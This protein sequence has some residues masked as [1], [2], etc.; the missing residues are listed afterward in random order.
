MIPFSRLLRFEDSIYGHSYFIRAAKGAIRC[1][2]DLY[3]HPEWREHADTTQLT[4]ESRGALRA[5]TNKNRPQ[6]M[7]P[8]PKVLSVSDQRPT[9]K[10]NRAVKQVDE[11]PS[12]R[13]LIEDKDVLREALPFL[14]KLKTFA[15]NDIDVWVLGYHLYKRLG[16][17]LLQLQALRKGLSVDKGDPDLHLCLI[18]FLLSSKY[19]QIGMTLHSVS[20]VSILPLGPSFSYK[21]PSIM[22]IITSIQDSMTR[23]LT[24]DEYNETF[25]DRH[26]HLPRHVLKGK[27]FLDVVLVGSII[28]SIIYRSRGKNVDGQQFHS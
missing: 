23:G 24:I 28:R 20:Y 19:G 10:V 7:K 5:E 4:S 1:Y 21:N 17:P 14:Q 16:K 22:S 13:S 15:K 11:D 8:G 25:L 26:S 12:G 9:G 3:D 6:G 18:D 2:L 27:K